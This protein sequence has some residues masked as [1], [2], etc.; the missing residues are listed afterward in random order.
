MKYLTE[1]AE[2]ALLKSLSNRKDAERDFMVIHLMLK[3]GLRC[4]EAAGLNNGDL[5]KKEILQVRKET[6]K[7]GKARPVP[8]NMRLQ[9]H[10][11]AYFKLKARLKE[12]VSDDAPFF[13]SRLGKRISYRAIYNL[14][15]KWLKIGRLDEGLSPHSLRHSFA[16]RILARYDNNPKS[17]PVI[18]RL[19]GHSSLDTTGVYLEPGCEDLLEAVESIS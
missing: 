2:K 7:R 6:A 13:V 18:Q 9:A 12:D 5:R 17:L 3:T 16:K 19:L 15:K 4:C 8:L 10:I 1:Y 14:V 11:K